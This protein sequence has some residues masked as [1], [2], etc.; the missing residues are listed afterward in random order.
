MNN[1]IY[2]RLISVAKSQDFTTYKDIAPLAGLDM[3]LDK[4]RA[5]IGEILG[6]ISTHEHRQG[7]PLL[8]VV[9]IHREDNICGPGFFKLAK[10]LGLYRGG[11]DLKFF[12][13]ELRRVHD[14][15]GKT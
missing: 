6:E 10:E 5:E 13:E 4:D 8:S 1:E 7:R 9:V 2:Q 11:N 3:S 15:W 14:C 12:I